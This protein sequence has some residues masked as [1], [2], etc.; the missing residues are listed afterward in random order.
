MIA[1]VVY[2]LSSKEVYHL[3]R[4]EVRARLYPLLSIPGLKLPRRQVYLHALDVY[5]QYPIDFEDALTVAQ[6]SHAKIQALYSYDRSFDRVP[7]LDR[8]EP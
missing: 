6:M 3:G 7:E 1:E 5:A 8:L 2:V 4:D